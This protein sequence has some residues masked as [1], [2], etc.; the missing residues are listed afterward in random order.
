MTPSHWIAGSTFF[1]L[2]TASTRADVHV[3][4][5]TGA[6][7]AEIQA[8]IDVSE[9]GDIVLVKSGTYS[10]FVVRNVDLSIVA[11][12]G[13]L[14]DVNGAIRVGPNH[15]SRTLLL[16]GL[17]VAGIETANGL[18]R[19]GLYAHDVGGL[20]L[21]RDCQLRG[22]NGFDGSCTVG[23]GALLENCA[24]ACFVDC[25]LVG[26]GLVDDAISPP[27]RGLRAY[28]SSVALY[29]GSVTGG[30]GGNDY[31]PCGTLPYG[32]SGDGTLGG[33]GVETEQAFLF[34][35]F[36]SITGGRGGD[37]YLNSVFCYN[38]GGG[39]PG[40][41]WI[42]GP[43]SELRSVTLAGGFWGQPSPVLGCGSHH[44]PIGPPYVGLAPNSVA[45]PFRRMTASSP[46]REQTPGRFDITGVAG[47]RIESVAIELTTF[48]WV[49]ALNGI[50]LF[51]LRRPQPLLQLGTVPAGGQLVVTG[52]V[53]ELGPGVQGVRALL[54]PVFV[55]G[56]GNGFLGPPVPVVLLDASF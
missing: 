30:Q 8:A 3:V 16:Q 35:A 25:Q 19:H 22:K 11:D 33:A 37:G 20:L 21:V 56:S 12:A 51:S 14:V 49:P 44:G 54:Q 40:L 9:D 15:A 2:A 34:A 6:P 29:S 7:F 36:T 38:G 13:A 26:G 24:K 1:L 4:A 55:P 27:G 23:S 31:F 48:V 28:Q 32:Y 52:P 5:P 17:R 42:S 53:G 39:G 18:T 45:A 43:Q 46:L 10:S 47:D 41:E 50:R